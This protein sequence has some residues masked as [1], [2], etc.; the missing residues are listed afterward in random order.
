MWREL[1]RRTRLLRPDGGHLGKEL[2]PEVGH[3]GGERLHA[4]DG[5]ES[6]EGGN[7]GI[8]DHVLAGLVGVKGTPRL[9]K[10][11]HLDVP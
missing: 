1:R 2:V 9:L 4:R 7:Q 11:V 3:A 5:S 6:E 8:L 10:L